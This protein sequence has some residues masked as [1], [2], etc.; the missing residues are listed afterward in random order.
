MPWSTVMHLF[1]ALEYS[2]VSKFLNRREEA[3]TK[4]YCRGRIDLKR[5][6]TSTARSFQVTGAP[7]IST[8]YCSQFDG[9]MIRRCRCQ[10][11]Q[12]RVPI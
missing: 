3:A 12:F 9:R 11:Q 8:V 4:D 1:V 2:P 10:C 7:A 6:S 5:A